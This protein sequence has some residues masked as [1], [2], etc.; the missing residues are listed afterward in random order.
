MFYSDDPVRD[1]ERHLED[2]DRQAEKL[3][4][5]SDCGGPIYDDHYYLIN[6][7]VICQSC[8]DDNYRKRTEDY[9]E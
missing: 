9:V 8:L 5:C 7:E 1:A 3:P 2:Q 6:D 4:V